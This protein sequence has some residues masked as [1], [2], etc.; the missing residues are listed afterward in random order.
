MRKLEEACDEFVA[1]VEGLWSGF[2]DERITDGAWKGCGVLA[3]TRLKI[4][5]ED[6]M[7]ESGRADVHR[8]RVIR[9]ARSTPAARPGAHPGE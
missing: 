3:P 7:D 2:S 5:I 4:W 8:G 1:R 9:R 6:L